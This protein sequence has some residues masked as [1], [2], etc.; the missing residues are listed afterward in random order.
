MRPPLLIPAR[1]ASGRCTERGNAMSDQPA[2]LEGAATREA[3]IRAH[4]VGELKAHD[5]P[6]QL[7]EYDPAWPT[8]F[9]R[10][11]SRIRRALGDRALLLEHTGSTAVPG[12]AAK[13]IIDITLVVPD[14]GDEPAYV[15]SLEAAGYVLRIREPDWFEHR[16]FKGPTRTSTSTSSRRAARRSGGWS[17]SG[18]GF[19]PT[20]RIGRSTNGRNASS[21]AGR[22]STSR[23]T[24]TPRRR[25][26]SGSSPGPV[27]LVDSR[28]AAR[29]RPD[30][31]MI[32]SFYFRRPA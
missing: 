31:H 14:S 2:A 21:R 9:E 15:P 12:L 32:R 19:G 23:T 1:P 16:V 30:T 3:E 6:I 22:G 27:S 17:A 11:A 10:E 18:T 5:A 13:P 26:S 7:A 24:P 4:T 8:L 29:Y 20:G 28:G 25:S